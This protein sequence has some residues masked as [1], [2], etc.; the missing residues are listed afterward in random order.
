MFISSS[1]ARKLL[2]TTALVSVISL[3]AFADPDSNALPTG[4]QV[5][6]GQA[7]INSSDNAMNINQGSDRAHVKFETF[8]IGSSASVAISQPSSNAIFLADVP[9]GG[10]S[11]I[12][13]QLTA[14]GKIFISNPDGVTFGEGARVDANSLVA[15][16]ARM[17]EE[18][19]QAADKFDFNKAGNEDGAIVNM[20]SINVADSGMAA[21]VAP[22]VKNSGVIQARL[23]K[24][25]LAGADT[26]VVDPYG[27]GM[28]SFAIQDGKTGKVENSGAISA[29][30]GQVMIG[31]DAKSAVDQVV[32]VSGFVEADSVEEKDGVII[33]NSNKGQTSVV[34]AVVSASGGTIK[35]LGGTVLIGD[36]VEMDVS[37]A[38][39][40]GKILVG[41]NF[42][43]K[44]PEANASIVVVDNDATLRANVQS[45]DAGEIVAWADDVMIFHGAIEAKSD[46]GKGGNVEISGATGDVEWASMD[47]S[48]V[49]PGHLLLDPTNITIQNGSFGFSDNLTTLT[50]AGKGN[51]SSGFTN[52]V[53][54]RPSTLA[55]PGA[56]V[57]LQATK[58]I[59]IKE[60]VTTDQGLTL[61]A[62]ND[63]VIGA[64]V[65]VTGGT[66]TIS[67]NANDQTTGTSH[68]SGKGSI[69]QSNRGALLTASNIS[70]STDFGTGASAAANDGSIGEENG[71]I[72]VAATNL[73]LT[74]KNAYVEGTGAQVL[75][76]ASKVTENLFIQTTAGAINATAFLTTNDTNRPKE[77]I[78]LYAAGALTN[79]AITSKRIDL[80]TVANFSDVTLTADL[81]QL[82]L[83][84]S[85]AAM[86]LNNDVFHTFDI[87]NGSTA[88]TLQLGTSTHKA[89]FTISGTNGGNTFNAFDRIALRTGQDQD[90]SGTGTFEFEYNF[91]QNGD[92]FDGG[93]YVQVESA[94]DAT[95]HLKGTSGFS[96]REL[97]PGQD[98]IV[99]GDG[100][101]N[102]A[103]NLTVINDDNGIINLAGKIRAG[104]DITITTADGA[105]S[106]IE[107]T[108]DGGVVAG[109]NLKFTSRHIIPDNQEM[110]SGA[111]QEDGNSFVFFNGQAFSIKTGKPAGRMPARRIQQKLPGATVM[112]LRVLLDEGDALSSQ[113]LHENETLN[114]LTDEELNKRL[115]AF[116]DSE[117]HFA[118]LLFNDFDLNDKSLATMEGN[119]D[120]NRLKTLLE[121]EVNHYEL[122]VSGMNHDEVMGLVDD[123]EINAIK[124]AK[125]KA[126]QRVLKALKRLKAQLGD[127]KVSA[128]MVYVIASREAQKGAK[129]ILDSEKSSGLFSSGA[130]VNIVDK[131]TFIKDVSAAIAKDMSRA[132]ATTSRA[133]RQQVQSGGSNVGWRTQM[134]SLASDDIE[135]VDTILQDASVVEKKG[136]YGFRRDAT[137]VEK[138][139][140]AYDAIRKALDTQNIG[141]PE[142]RAQLAYAMAQSKLGATVSKS[143]RDP[144]LVIVQAKEQGKGD[145]SSAKLNAVKAAYGLANDGTSTFDDVSNALKAG[146]S[147]AS[148]SEIKQMAGQ[149]MSVRTK[150]STSDV[151]L[152]GTSLFA[153]PE[154]S[155]SNPVDSGAGVFTPEN[156]APVVTTQSGGDAPKPEEKKD[157]VPPPVE[158]V[159]LDDLAKQVDEGAKVETP[160]VTPTVETPIVEQQSGDAPLKSQ[161]AEVLTTEPKLP[162]ET[163]TVVTPKVETPIVEQQSGDAPLKSQSAEVLT[164]EP[165]PTVE[166][167]TVVTP[168]VE[169]PKVETP[170]V[171]TPTVVE[172][173]PEEVVTHEAEQHSGGTSIVETP[174]VE[175][176]TKTVVST[177]TP[178]VVAPTKT[179]VSTATT[180]KVV[181]SGP[182]PVVP[183]PAV[184]APAAVPT[185]KAEVRAARVQSVRMAARQ[186]GQS[187]MA[188]GVSHAKVKADMIKVATFNLK[189]AGVKNAAHEA[190]K[191]VEAELKALEEEKKAKRQAA[192]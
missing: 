158:Q 169:T 178:K 79:S 94:D 165:K 49:V 163:A 192:R 168:T 162:V 14:N 13:G 120:E 35:A 6:S 111:S 177:T 69:K 176:P 15:T 115:D 179:V 183:A 184:V 160:V 27:D 12:Y 36:D 107:I 76:A 37:H 114:G 152:T 9:K 45:G 133:E 145:W 55:S 139:E 141:T 124:R 105:N 101:P 81:I 74:S 22:T 41:G 4:A 50:F 161:S 91:V 38:S 148:D 151:D 52:N 42:Q 99:G 191:M 66:N 54:I 104:K 146:F 132:V 39:K 34:D 11:E 40:A 92:V 127:E 73:T 155:V 142:N 16:T 65:T 110:E 136:V 53:Y 31:V 181:A 144:M 185:T 46:E 1:K 143:G 51:S 83:T 20:G 173:K 166:T 48:G 56:T 68:A 93:R 171:V 67:M 175:T 149:L 98:D 170:T 122:D 17:S 186:V 84:D 85:S 167:A 153:E 150:G 103:G 116:F 28:V 60:A 80:A 21:L 59:T 26:F 57:T 23:A 63:I 117:V 82:A 157:D 187:Q 96:M 174:T 58:D 88:K 172:P 3:S 147:K 126:A 78:R 77:S 119:L 97:A 135:K 25:T 180:K 188:R 134:L 61:Q 8:N 138:F 70:L 24:V 100:N 5:V 154:G 64:S 95:I 129:E 125:V 33:L 123:K 75:Q 112:N 106:I 71:P 189:K 86:T 29:S 113:I 108:E 87:T 118:D 72:R 131:D 62:G 90:I 159:S 30:G 164:T 128:A 121:Q 102:V 2:A 156:P 47:L 109:N 7:A 130:L 43:G 19:F 18:S 140:S 182:A 10:K 44:G 32:N 89:G 190:K 137:D